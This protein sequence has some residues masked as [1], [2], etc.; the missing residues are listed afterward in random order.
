M[1]IGEKVVRLRKD[2]GWSQLDLA[3]RIGGNV[4]QQNIQ[5]DHNRAQREPATGAI[6]V[7]GVVRFR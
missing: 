3:D 6:R 2:R 7:Y 5:H 1:D 4:K